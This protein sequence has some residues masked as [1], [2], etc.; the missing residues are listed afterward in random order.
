MR[1]GVRPQDGGEAVVDGRRQR[2]GG[3]EAVVDRDD[4]HARVHGEA[5]DEPLREPVP[6]APER[7]PAAVHVDEDGQLRVRSVGV[8]ALVMVRVVDADADVGE[9]G[10]PGEDAG[11][12]VRDDEVDRGDAVRA[13]AGG[14]DRLRVHALERRRGAEQAARAEDGAEERVRELDADVDVG[15]AAEEERDRGGEEEDEGSSHAADDAAARGRHLKGRGRGRKR[16]ENASEQGWER[17]AGEEGWERR[18]GRG[19]LEARAA[20]ERA[21]DAREACERG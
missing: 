3:R 18:A 20:E 11:V 12:R 19:G 21:S 9:R 2:D 10:D 5:A 7:V 13:R 17:R 16:G 6:G 8:V 15:V 1:R 4:E 14:D